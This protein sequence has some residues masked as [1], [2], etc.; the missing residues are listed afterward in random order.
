MTISEGDIL[1]IV[2]SLLFPDDVIMQN[3]FHLVLTT[4][5]GTGDEAD[6]TVDAAEYVQDI[7]DE[8]LANY[9]AEIDGDVIKVYVY[10]S[11]DDDFDE[12]GN[13]LLVI[14]G[15]AATEMLP[16]GV[17]LMQSFFTTDPDVQGRKYWGGFPEGN[18]EAGSWIG[19]VLTSAVAAAAALVGTFTASVGGNVYQPVV[20]SP[21]KTSALGYS[22]VVDTNTIVNYQRRRRPGVGI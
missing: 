4:I 6:V 22:G 2:P 5:N 10:D 17:A 20:W 15:S 8:F 7:Y 3:V 21:T 1:R 14:G 16:H 9:V 19:N 11:I 13:D 12:I 18:Q